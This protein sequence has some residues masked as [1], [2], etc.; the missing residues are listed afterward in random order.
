MLITN[1]RKMKLLN[2]LIMIGF[3]VII[4]S[5]GDETD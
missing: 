3:V 1:D 4:R 5:N 2:Y